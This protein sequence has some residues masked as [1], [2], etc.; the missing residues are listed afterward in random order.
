MSKIFG[1]SKSKAKNVN[2]NLLTQQFS[3]LINQGVDANNRVNA[4]LGGDTSG[5]DAF[6]RATGF[7]F[8][9]ERGFGDIGSQAAARGVLRSGAA[10]RSMQDFGLG[11]QNRYA[12][13]Y[14]Q[15]LLGQTQGA[16]GAG[17]I[18]A[19]TGQESTSRSKPGLGGLIGG[20]AAGAAGLGW[21]PLAAGG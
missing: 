10:G 4:L 3:P 14:L 19:S 11:L 6:K 9:L 8:D 1:G 16:L 18:L 13:T 17:G 12:Q 20:A 21:T 7:N 2:N 5:F 15:S